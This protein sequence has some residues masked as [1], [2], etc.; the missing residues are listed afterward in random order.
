VFGNADPLFGGVMGG[1]DD[2]HSC[3]VV[4]ELV[5]VFVLSWMLLCDVV[6]HVVDH[7]MV[8][9]HHGGGWLQGVVGVVCELMYQDLV[10][11]E[12]DID[13]IF[14]AQKRLVKACGVC[15]RASVMT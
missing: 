9:V 15:Q 10:A 1:I 5:F 14:L 11:L 7:L 13:V 12:L 2:D 3:I 6:W 8:G 4:L